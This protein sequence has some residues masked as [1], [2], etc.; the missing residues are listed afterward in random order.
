MTRL[1]LTNGSSR[2]FR[3][4]VIAV[5]RIMNP[6]HE[7]RQRF[8]AYFSSPAQVHGSSDVEC[9]INSSGLK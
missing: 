1:L 7:Y 8:A 9:E 3:G 6:S 2:R 5:R 4:V